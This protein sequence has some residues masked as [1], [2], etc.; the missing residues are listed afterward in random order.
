MSPKKFQ[1]NYIEEIGTKDTASLPKTVTSE[2]KNKHI[3][4]T[5]KS[6]KSNRKWSLS[7]V[8]ALG[9]RIV[10]RSVNCSVNHRTVHEL[11][12]K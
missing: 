4:S 2:L 12:F 10:L 9:I 6:L 11:H 8:Q 7:R 1:Y 3:L 5:L